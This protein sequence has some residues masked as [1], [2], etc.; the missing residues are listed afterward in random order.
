MSFRRQE[1]KTETEEERGKLNVCFIDFGTFF[2]TFPPSLL[3]Y[4][5]LLLSRWD[6]GLIGMFGSIEMLSP[7]PSLPIPLSCS[8][9]INVLG[10]YEEMEN[11]K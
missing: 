10:C 6:F 7:F 1:K 9:S 8:P 11:K 2:S 4:T 5:L 3:S